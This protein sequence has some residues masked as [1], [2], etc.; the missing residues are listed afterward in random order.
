MSPTGGPD[1][2]LVREQIEQ[3]P[4]LPDA[5]GIAPV[6][7]EDPDPLESD[8]LVGANRRLVCQRG[9]DRQPVVTALADQ[10]ARER[11][12]SVAAETA[13]M[14]G[15]REEEV[16]VRVPVLVLARFGK[17]RQADDFTLVLDREGGCVVAAL[18]LVEQVLTRDLAPPARDLGLGADLRQAVDVTWLERPQAHPFTL[19]LR[20][21]RDHRSVKKRV[22][23][24]LVERGLAESRTQAQALVLAGRVPGHAKPGEQVEDSAA[25]AVTAG[26][27]YVSRGGIKLANALEAFGVDA[28]GRECLDVG[29]STG[30][31]TDVLLQ[32]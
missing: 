28:A 11:A 31:F 19:Q 18:G 8:R 2:E 27:P 23:V 21:G 25:L 1:S 10:P 5:D 17:L 24:L 26:D 3:Q 22:D 32:R 4:V 15:R 29:A 9:V 7:A 12:H 16:D 30:G 13:T 6:S 20:H 14:K